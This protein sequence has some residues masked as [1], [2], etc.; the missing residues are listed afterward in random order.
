[1]SRTWHPEGTGKGRRAGYPQGP[2]EL[3]ASYAHPH[4]LPQHAAAQ[5]LQR[6]HR[7]QL[8][9]NTVPQRALVTMAPAA[10]VCLGPTCL[11]LPG[12][13]HTLLTRLAP[14][15]IEGQPVSE[16]VLALD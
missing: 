12:P 11:A 4:S 5:S 3:A 15:E 1:M 16:L 14:T 6:F 7:S 10:G 2:W 9:S 13:P 8:P